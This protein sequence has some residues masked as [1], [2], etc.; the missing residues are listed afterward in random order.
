ME[1]NFEFFST[2]HE[3]T[4]SNPGRVVTPFN[5]EL[6]ALRQRNEARAKAIREQGMSA[7]AVMSSK[8]TADLK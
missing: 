2:L 4:A 5:A 7:V 6:K 1:F 3:V 8:S